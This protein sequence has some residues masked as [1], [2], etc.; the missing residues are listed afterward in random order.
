M[1][2]IVQKSLAPPK[3]ESHQTNITVPDTTGKY[4][5]KR[6][7]IPPTYQ[8]WVNE[9]VIEKDT[10]GQFWDMEETLPGLGEKGN[11]LCG[12]EKG[13]YR[14]TNP[15][16]R[17][18]TGS[19]RKVIKWKHQCSKA[20]CPECYYDSWIRRRVKD[21][22][23]RMFYIMRS[24]KSKPKH[25]V[26][27]PPDNWNGKDLADYLRLAGLKGGMVIRHPWVF[28]AKN[29]KEVIRWK[30]SDINPKSEKKIPSVAIRRL[31]YHVIGFGFMI[32][33]EK[34]EKISGGWTYWNFG[35]REKKDIERTM[36]YLLTHTGIRGRKQTVRWFGF[37][38][39]NKIEVQYFE[40]IE[41]KKCPYCKQEMEMYKL[42]EGTLIKINNEHKV[43]YR[44]YRFRERVGL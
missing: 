9:R 11:N 8:D 14:C 17:T 30:D 36:A 28:R 34:F 25:V 33:S 21:S 16:C 35:K 22:G 10:R 32:N 39:N 42:Y 6:K 26:F 24:V 20:E 4:L 44:M 27:S 23:R 29:S 19:K 15:N 18:N 37:C 7:P 40:K 13:E 1:P 43:R 41:P 2:L 31:H 38:A 3:H 12:T 5:K